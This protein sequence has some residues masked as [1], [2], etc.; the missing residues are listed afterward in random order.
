V[1]NV[2][3]EEKD[4]RIG[5]RMPVVAVVI[6]DLHSI[7]AL[8]LR[9]ACKAVLRLPWNSPCKYM[10]K[11]FCVWKHDHLNM[12]DLIQLCVCVRVCVCVCERETTYFTCARLIF[13]QLPGTHDTEAHSKLDYLLRAFRSPDLVLV[14]CSSSEHARWAVIKETGLT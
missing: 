9:T 5:T 12:Q 10:C 13:T 14:S 8:V 3:G 4:C 7:T 11:C 6:L 2:V 1:Q